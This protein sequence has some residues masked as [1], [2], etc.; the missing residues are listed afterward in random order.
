MRRPH[1][2]ACSAGLLTRSPLSDAVLF[3]WSALDYLDPAD[4]YATPGSTGTSES[5]PWDWFHINSVDKDAAGNYLV[6]SR[7]MH[8]V[9]YVSGASGEVLWTLGGNNSSFTSTSDDANATT[10]YWQHDARWRA[11]QTVRDPLHQPARWARA[12]G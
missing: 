5:D 4:S 1:D 3:S 11:N 9:Y 10:F 8:A 12:Q 6:S 2:L 7:H